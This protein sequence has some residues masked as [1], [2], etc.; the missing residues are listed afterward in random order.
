MKPFLLIVDNRNIKNIFNYKEEIFLGQDGVSMLNDTPD[1][2][3]SFFDWQFTYNKIYTNNIK[4][5]K[6]ICLKTDLLPRF[7]NYILPQ[8]NNEF[9][10]I[11]GYSDF[12]P[13]INFK[14]EYNILINDK[15]VKYWYMN[16]MK[17][18]TS[19]TYSLP[20]GLGSK[21]FP[22]VRKELV[23][24][25]I[26]N[27]RNS[28]KIENKIT[29]KIFCCFANKN[30]NIV[31]NEHAIRPKILDIILSHPKT[32]D[33]YQ[34]LTFEEFLLTLSKYKYA[35]VPYGNGLDPNP[36]C[37]LSLAL[38]TIPIIYKTD[39]VVDMF[40]DNDVVIFFEKFEDILNKEI[41]V[42]KPYVDFEFLTYKYW[43]NK[44]KSKI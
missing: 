33:F 42:D 21:Y 7:I 38:Y 26:L 29:N 12:S 27:I 32:F 36:T 3:S 44:I 34:K 35:I 24:N 39:N 2:F 37:W 5:P 40:S 20:V 6:T 4:E 15:R 17:N 9:I 16:N 25:I 43:V 23:E 30:Y 1:F 11:T 28:I 31:G 22:N 14:R 19:K 41:Y 10:L 8:I 18:K 13:E